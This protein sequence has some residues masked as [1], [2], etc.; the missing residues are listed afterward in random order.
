MLFRRRKLPP[1]LRDALRAAERATPPRRLWRRRL[2][3]VLPGALVPSLLIVIAYLV[4]HPG[5]VPPPGIGGPSVTQ[6]PAESPPASPRAMPRV[7]YGT[8]SP[9]PA[10]ADAPPITPMT[11]RMRVVD[12]DTLATADERLRLSGIDAPEMGQPCERGGV[13]YDCG[14]AARAA[15]ARIVGNGGV[16]CEA[17]GVDQYRRQVVRCVGADGQDIG[18]ALVAQGWA[19]AY[20][21]YSR[22]YVPQE[23]MA[24]NRGLGLWAGRFMPPW[25]WRHR[26]RY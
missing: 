7:I 1:E 17:I 10:P 15:M 4:W 3:M 16:T 24:R 26:Q 11:G 5:I 18:A 9:R 22:D 25:E 12:G 21:Q 19:M 23:D 8:A 6:M 20:R 13:T 2:A 14:E